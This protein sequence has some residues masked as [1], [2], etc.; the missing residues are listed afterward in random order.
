MVKYFS[1][2]TWK[3]LTPHCCASV[4]HQFPNSK[5]LNLV[6]RRFIRCNDKSKLPHPRNIEFATCCLGVANS[7]RGSLNMANISVGPLQ[8]QG[9]MTAAQRFPPK[10]PSSFIDSSDRGVFG[11]M[12]T[13]LMTSVYENHE[14]VTVGVPREPLDFLARAVEAGHPQSVAIHL[15]DAV[16]QVLTENFV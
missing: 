16:T 14:I 12:M 8:C 15:T 9:T 1:Q 4:W 2:R 7:S 6:L 10:V 3:R 13:L 11:S 5:C